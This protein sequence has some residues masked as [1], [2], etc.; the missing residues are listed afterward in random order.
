M[1]EMEYIM[2]LCDYLFLNVQSWGPKESILVHN[3]GSMLKYIF[4]QV[5][6]LPLNSVKLLVISEIWLWYCV[7]TPVH[8]LL[9][10]LEIRHCKLFGQVDIEPLI[11]ILWIS[12][13]HVSSRITGVSNQPQPQSFFC[14]TGI[15]IRVLIFAKLALYIL[16]HSS[17]PVLCRSFLS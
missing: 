14:G 11:W 5:D 10:L 16:S 12:T 2:F 13:S 4:T 15:W 9:V 8:F 3:W 7:T 6:Q 1:E 17:S